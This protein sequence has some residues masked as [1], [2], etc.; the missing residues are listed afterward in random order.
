MA[1]LAFILLLVLVWGA[2]VGAQ[3]DPG[4]SVTHVVQAGDTLF[5]IA[6]RYGVDMEA[7]ALV[8]GIDDVNDIHTGQTLK[9]PAVD[10]VVLIDHIVQPGDTLDTLAWRY[11]VTPRELAKRNHILRED[12]LFAGQTL[13]IAQPGALPGV[14]NGYRYVVQ[15]GDTLLDIARRHGL[16]PG[17]LRRANPSLPGRVPLLYPGQCLLIPGDAAA[18]PLRALPDP[19][20]DLTLTP[21]PLNQGGAFGLQMTTRRP[22]TAIGLFMDRPVTFPYGDGLHHAAVFGVGRLAQP[23]LYPLAVYLR[24]EADNLFAFETRVRVAAGPYGNE[25]IP[26]PARLQAILDPATIEPELALLA[27]YMTPVTAWR[28]WEDT[29]GRPSAGEITSYFGTWRSYGG[30][31]ETY[32][33]GVDFGAPT[34]SPVQAPAAGRVV[35]VDTLAVRGK[36]TIIDHGWGV[37]TGYWHQSEVY[38]MVGDVVEAGQIIGLVGNTGLSTGPHLHWEMWAGGVP[39]DPMPW[40]KRTLP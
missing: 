9:I 26:V 14:P 33:P 15:P 18:P 22:V 2:A 5:R 11:G 35:F 13:H 31:L 19:I 3:D 8:N 12:M 16:T 6:L 10:G 37:Y 36:A 1:R 21:L 27:G 24:D 4:T 29:F 28:Y 39:V 30:Q 20:L 25:H 40:M 34:G 7:L 38:V 32:H 23:G 17:A